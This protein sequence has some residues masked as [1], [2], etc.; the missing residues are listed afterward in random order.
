MSVISKTDWDLWKSDPVTK[1]FFSTIFERRED[2]KEELA[3]L[4][5]KDSYADAIQ[6]GYMK[7]CVDILGTEYGE[8]GQD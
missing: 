7:A 5:G 6:V 8:V 3:N 2:I 4:G 1:A